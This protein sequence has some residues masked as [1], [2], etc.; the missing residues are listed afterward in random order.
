M[1]I[2]WCLWRSTTYNESWVLS[3]VSQEAFYFTMTSWFVG[4]IIGSIVGS[5]ILYKLNKKNIFVSK[6][7]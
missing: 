4:A 1:H 6:Q 3:V 7:R 5:I 2:A